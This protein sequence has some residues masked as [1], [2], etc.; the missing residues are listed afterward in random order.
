M[1][2]EA[3]AGIETA[4]ER[5]TEFQR[6]VSTGKRLEKPSDDPSGT[7]TA[8]TEHAGLATVEQYTRAATSVGSKLTVIDTLLS[9]MVEKLTSASTAVTSARG[10]EQTQAQREA[11]A[12]QLESVKASLLDNFNA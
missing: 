6:Q 11:A 7:M 5:L 3:G 8:I 2:R 9:D 12:Q 1:Y 4:T 10:T